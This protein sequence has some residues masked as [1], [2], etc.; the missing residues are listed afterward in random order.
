MIYFA[1]PKMTVP[2]SA[3][4]RGAAASLLALPVLWN[5]D[6]LAVDAGRR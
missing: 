4:L 3:R 5:A 2:A 6:V 1:A